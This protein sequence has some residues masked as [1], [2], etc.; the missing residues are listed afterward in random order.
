MDERLIVD[1]I[2]RALEEVDYPVEIND[3][4]DV[5]NFLNDRNNIRLEVYE[6][7]EQLYNQLMEDSEA[8]DRDG[9]LG[10]RVNDFFS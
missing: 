3:I 10:S 4:S 1:K 9:G 7:V 2:N 8:D 6:V 5:E